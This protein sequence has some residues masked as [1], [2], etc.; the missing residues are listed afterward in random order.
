VGSV[1]G[2]MASVMAIPEMHTIIQFFRL[3][4]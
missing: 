2:L 1:R 4:A 3:R